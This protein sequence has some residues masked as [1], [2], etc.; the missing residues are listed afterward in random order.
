MDRRK[1]L[2][3]I[4]LALLLYI[5][6]ITIIQ[7]FS[8][9][10][11]VPLHFDFDGYADSHGSK[12]TVF[13]IP[14]VATVILCL[15]RFLSR[16][17]E[18]PTLNIPERMKKNRKLSAVFVRILLFYGLLLCVDIATEIPLIAK[19][20]YTKISSASSIIIGFMFLSIVG[21]FFYARKKMTRID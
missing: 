1:V 19:G 9:P 13:A 11:T 4:N 21:Y 20:H 16:N 5:W 7:F 3:I 18:S 14:L 17:P 10:E 15:L 8:L 12:Y 6:A 2:G